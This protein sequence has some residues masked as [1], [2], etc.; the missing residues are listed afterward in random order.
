MFFFSVDEYGSISS[1]I[2]KH[3]APSPWNNQLRQFCD[4]SLDDL[5]F[6]IR[7]NAKVLQSQILSAVISDGNS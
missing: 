6:F 7:K 4:I 5:S 3:L 2:E 1:V